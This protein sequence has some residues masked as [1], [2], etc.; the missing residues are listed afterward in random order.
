MLVVLW[1]GTPVTDFAGEQCYTT[2]TL[3]YPGPRPPSVPQTQTIPLL[4]S[5]ATPDQP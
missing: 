2:M 5:V 3:I 1:G 4:T